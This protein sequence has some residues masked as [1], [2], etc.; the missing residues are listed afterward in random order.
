MSHLKNILV[1]LQNCVGNEDH[2]AG[3]DLPLWW[4]KDFTKQIAQ[5]ADNYRASQRRISTVGDMEQDDNIPFRDNQDTMDQAEITYNDEENA[6]AEEEF[7]QNWLYAEEEEK[8][9]ET[10]WGAA[11]QE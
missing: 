6:G 10:G 3:R 4:S 11:Y 9:F 7:D 1:E 8:R 5:D 2:D